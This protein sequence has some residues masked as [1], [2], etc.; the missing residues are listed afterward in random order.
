MYGGKVNKGVDGFRAA[1]KGPLISRVLGVNDGDGMG[2]RLGAVL[3]M[4]IGV[5]LGGALG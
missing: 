3:G 2:T 4:S 1:D 5:S